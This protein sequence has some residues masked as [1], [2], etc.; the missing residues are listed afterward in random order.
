MIKRD[1][2]KPSKYISIASHDSSGGVGGASTFVVL[3]QMV[4]ELETKLKVRQQAVKDIS[5]ERE[6]EYINIFQKVDNLRKERAHMIKTFSNYKFLVVTLAYYAKN[7]PIFDTILK[8]DELI[9]DRNDQDIEEETTEPMLTYEN[10]HVV[11][12]SN[13]QEPN[14]NMDFEYDIYVN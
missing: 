12:I 2:G 3:F 1:I 13:E 10:E 6:I 9:F 14:A 5:R 4:E 7:R 11:T 8:M